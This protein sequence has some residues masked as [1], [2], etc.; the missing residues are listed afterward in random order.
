MI[1]AFPIFFP[2]KFAKLLRAPVY[3]EHPPVTAS[4]C[5][6]GTSSFEKYKRNRNRKKQRKTFETCKVK[7]NNAMSYENC[8]SSGHDNFIEKLDMVIQLRTTW[9]SKCHSFSINLDPQS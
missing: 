1:T 2:V 9:S 3:T 7:L 4:V 5:L 8:K 6:E